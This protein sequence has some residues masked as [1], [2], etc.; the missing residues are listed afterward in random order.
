MMKKRIVL[1][2]FTLLILMMS[3]A[4]A[5][6]DKPVIDIITSDRYPVTGLESAR[7]QGLSVNVYNLDDGKRLVKRL[8]GKL[9]PNQQAAKRQ[10]ENTLKRMGADAGRQ[11]FSNAFQAQQVATQS[12]LE[13]YPAIVFN[14]G[15]AGVYGVTEVSEALK[16]YHAW[17]EVQR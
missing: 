15:Q 7:A 4:E 1:G 12:R 2:L 13:R 3:V 16:H 5:K 8:A 9:P 6:Q 11:A 14:Q 17:R 10:L